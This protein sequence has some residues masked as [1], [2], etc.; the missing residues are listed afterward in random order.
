MP[1]SSFLKSIAAGFAALVILAAGAC[2]GQDSNRAKAHALVD[3]AIQMSDTNQAVKLLWQASDIDPTLNESYIY[4]G[5]YYNSREDFAKVV[6]VYQKLIKYQPREVS[7][8]LNIGEA[9]M[10]F[11]PPKY[12]EALAAYR[13]AYE[14]DA[15]SSF[16]A[17]RIGQILAHQGNRIEAGRFLKQASADSAKNATVAAEAQK[18]L[19]QLGMF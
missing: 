14:I 8:Y 11:T 15:Q 6:E 18:E 16:A 1:P 13:K 12:Q 3:A 17:L 5:L 10:S 19:R 2:W 4:L 7:A 9:Y